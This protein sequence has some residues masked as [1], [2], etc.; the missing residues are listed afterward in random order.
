M[1]LHHQHKLD[2]LSFMPLLCIPYGY[3]WSIYDKDKSV[4]VC[5][6]IGLA[7]QNMQSP[8]RGDASAVSARGATLAELVR[9]DALGHTVWCM[10]KSRGR[11][12]MRVA[13]WCL[14]IPLRF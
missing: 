5:L 9:Q 4:L 14:K 8:A 12:V 13:A 11:D 6:S 2:M 10:R 3:G 1:Q 7:P